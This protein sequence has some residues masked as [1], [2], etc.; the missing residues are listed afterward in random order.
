MACFLGRQYKIIL[1]GKKRR[2][3]I[4]FD[5]RELTALISCFY[6]NVD[7]GH[8]RQRIKIMKAEKGQ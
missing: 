7:A 6:F 8:A 1:C 4:Q 5:W 3:K 2:R